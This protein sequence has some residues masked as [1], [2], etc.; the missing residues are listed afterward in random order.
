MG[1]IT[2]L[3][4]ILAVHIFLALDSSDNPHVCYGYGYPGTQLS[5][6]PV[7][8]IDVLGGTTH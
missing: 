6:P 3:I 8:A 7:M 5:M 1:S 2:I 4:L